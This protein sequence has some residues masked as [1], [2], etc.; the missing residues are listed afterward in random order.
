MNWFTGIVV[1]LLIWW[2]VIFMV[3]PWGVQRDESGPQITGPGAPKDPLLKKKFII[4]TV[5][6]FVIWAIIAALISSDLLS[7]REWAAQAPL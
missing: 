5:L 1:Y 7:F 2:V 6:S 4:T 3:L